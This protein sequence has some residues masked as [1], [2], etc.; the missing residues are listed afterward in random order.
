[1]YVLMKSTLNLHISKKKSLAP[2]YPTL[3]PTFYIS[4]V[5]MS[6]FNSVSTD[7]VHYIQKGAGLKKS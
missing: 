2:V 5:G 3:P 7:T 4:R 1:M 6:F